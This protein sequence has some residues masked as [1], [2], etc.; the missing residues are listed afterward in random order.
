[1]KHKFVK[2]LLDKVPPIPVPK[3]SVLDK[4]EYLGAPFGRKRWRS[5]KPD[6]IY[7]WDSMHGEIEVYSRRGQHFGVMN[8]QGIMYKGP[9]KGRKINV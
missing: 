1:M 7:E 6:R 8:P 9:V 4:F 5:H 2:R 3:P